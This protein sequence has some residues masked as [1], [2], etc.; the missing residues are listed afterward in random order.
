VIYIYTYIYIYTH[1]GVLFSHKKDKTAS[2]AGKWIGLEII[3][4]SEISQTEKD[5][6][7]ALSQCGIQSLNNECLEHQ[8]GAA[9]SGNRQKGRG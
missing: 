2:S 9:W 6:N 3:L 8:K 4:L 1:Y 7:L 5:G